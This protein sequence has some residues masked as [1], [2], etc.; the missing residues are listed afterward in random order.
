MDL[1]SNKYLPE[2][3]FPYFNNKILLKNIYMKQSKKIFLQ[4]L[5]R[6]LL[7]CTF[8]GFL[9]NS[10]EAQ[11]RRTFKQDAS[12]QRENTVRRETAR[13][14]PP[15]NRNAN[16]APR[17]SV[18]TRNFEPRNRTASP[19]ERLN[20][21]I[22]EFSPSNRNSNVGEPAN[23]NTVNSSPANGNSNTIGRERAN[24]RNFE[25]NGRNGNSVDRVNG[26]ARNSAPQRNSNQG[27]RVT[28]NNRNRNSNVHR[29]TNIQINNYRYT[30]VQRNTYRPYTRS[31]YRYGGHAYYSY[32][33][34]YY[35][36][37]RPFYWGPTWHPWGF[38]V[39]RIGFGSIIISL[40][41]QRYYYNNGVY[42]MPY[43]TG[44]TVVQ[45][46]YGARI[47]TLPENYQTVIVNGT[48]NNYYYGGTYYEKSDDGYTVVPPVAGTI[49]ENLPEGGE[50]V[51]IGD[52]TYVKIGETYYQPI[53][54]DGKNV[55]EVV[56]VQK[57]K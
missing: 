56:D 29:T 55:Y 18:N 57:D 35:H 16:S 10:G 14:S 33:P 27:N 26:T 54:L 4:H 25:P 39:A 38:F 5:S 8:S 48:T 12:P 37:Y 52:F 40:D 1:R 28:S 42:Y 17:E 50:E 34:F 9:F 51:R 22:R 43:N 53:Q 49:V 24:S 44:Y 19:G 23:G 13:N 31:P 7:V 15:S 6:L 3:A 45:A 11:Q 21:N 47:N 41:N 32:H 20:E 36:A 46:P 30:T 2:K